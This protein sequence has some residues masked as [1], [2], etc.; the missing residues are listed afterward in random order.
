MFSKFPFTAK[1]GAYF[2][3]TIIVGSTFAPWLAPYD[4]DLQDTEISLSSPNKQNYHIAPCFDQEQN[5]LH[6]H[7]YLI[8]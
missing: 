6:E 7:L 5:I 2:L 4:Y 1:L 3:I 8:F